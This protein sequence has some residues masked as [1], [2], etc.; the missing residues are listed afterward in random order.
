MRTSECWANCSTAKI[1]GSPDRLGGI[2]VEQ[3]DGFIGMGATIVWTAMRYAKL[4]PIEGIT[5][6]CPDALAESS[7]G[8]S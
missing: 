5:D 3:E 1:V 6:N 8:S 4:L 2:T 7:S